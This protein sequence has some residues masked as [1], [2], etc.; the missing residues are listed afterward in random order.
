MAARVETP[1]PL[2]LEKIQEKQRRERL[3]AIRHEEQLQKNEERLAT[4]L[5]R[6]RAPVIR[7]VGKRLMPRTMLKSLVKHR[8]GT[9]E[10]QV[11]VYMHVG[12]CAC[13]LPV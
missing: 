11:N 13:V 5:E 7:Q 6:S 4:S 12:S 8:K 1:F 2:R 10:Q 3:R 9:A